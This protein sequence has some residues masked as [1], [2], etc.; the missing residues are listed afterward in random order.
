MLHGKLWSKGSSVIDFFLRFDWPDDLAIIVVKSLVE[1]VDELIVD[2]GDVIMVDAKV[3][4]IDERL[5]G[6]QLVQNN[7]VVVLKFKV[8][9]I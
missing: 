4:S 8:Y 9:S 6:G 7:D 3:L 1:H 5:N 2:H